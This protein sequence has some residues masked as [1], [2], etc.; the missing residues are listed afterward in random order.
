[1]IID[2]PIKTGDRIR[3]KLHGV[4]WYATLRMGMLKGIRFLTTRCVRKPQVRRSYYVD[5]HAL[6]AALDTTPDQLDRV[7]AR[8]KTDLG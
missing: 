4:G 5:R 1:M 6:R 7:M 8:L 2:P 3:A